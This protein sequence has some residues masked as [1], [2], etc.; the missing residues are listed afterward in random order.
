MSN[1]VCIPIMI[2][3]QE[4]VNRVGVDDLTTMIMEALEQ[5]GG[6]LS[7]MPLFNNSFVL[8]QIK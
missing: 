7:P 8:R 5:H 6:G 3:L 4:V 2:S 1:W